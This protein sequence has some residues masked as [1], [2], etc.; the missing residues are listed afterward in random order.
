MTTLWEGLSA[1]WRACIAQAWTAYRFGSLPIGVVIVDAA[2]AVIS[3]GRNMGF[4]TD[5]ASH[6]LAKSM[7]AHAELVAL[8][9]LKRPINLRQSVLY[10]S[11]EPCAMCTGAIRLARVGELR[12][13]SSDPHAG[14]TNL[15][16]ASTYMRGH[17]GRVVGPESELL[18]Q[19][20]AALLIERVIGWREAGAQWA[21]HWARAKPR[22]MAFARYLSTRGLAAQLAKQGAP[23]EGMLNTL[24]REFARRPWKPASGT[25]GDK[26]EP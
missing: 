1:P 3:R 23:A 18:D 17:L 20:L 14:G 2:G 9:K 10:C 21:G 4:H 6:A 8:G 11:T 7:I 15:L 22:A 16:G 5:P 12:F 26:I 24:E 19:L 25:V 13:A